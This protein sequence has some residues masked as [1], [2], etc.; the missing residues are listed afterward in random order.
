MVMAK[1]NKLRANKANG[2]DNISP[3]LLVEIKDK[4][5]LPLTII[6]QESFKSDKYPYEWKLANVTPIHK[7]DSHSHPSN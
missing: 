3:K 1:L 5:F 7:K 2:V 6:F 4:I